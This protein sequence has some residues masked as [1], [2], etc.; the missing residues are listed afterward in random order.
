MDVT[1]KGQNWHLC[2]CV[3]VC[4]LHTCVVAVSSIHEG[5]TSW[6]CYS[7][8]SNGIQLMTELIEG[9]TPAAAD[10]TAMC[11]CAFLCV[12]SVSAL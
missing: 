1:E 8:G 10:K 6:H 9:L 3:C 5:E 11:V 4:E 2:E 7:S 12:Y